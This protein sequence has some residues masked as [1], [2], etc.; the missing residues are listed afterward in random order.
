MESSSTATRFQ[1]RESENSN[2]SDSSSS[3]NG[4][5]DSNLHSMTGKTK[6]LSDDDFLRNIFSN[7][8]SFLGV[9]EEV[10][11]MVKELMKLKTQVSTQKGLVKELIDGVYLKL[12]SEK[13]MESFIEESELDEAPPS[14]QLKT[15]IDDIL[16]IL[17]ILLSEKRIDEAIAILEMEE[18]NFKRLMVELGDIPSDVLMLYKSAISDMKAML[19][20]ESTLVAENSRISAPELQKAL[21]GICRL[22]ARSFMKLYGETSPFASEF[23]QW[24]YEEIEVFAVS[25]ARYV[26]SARRNSEIGV[27]AMLD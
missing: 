26:I 24:V 4:D 9:F 23:I 25:F 13:T 22:A 8:S 1:F 5:H 16:E 10:K 27:E 3:D 20:L 19:T 14:S 6:A 2:D 11:D 15:H 17:D 12:L 21:V 18:E 7:Y